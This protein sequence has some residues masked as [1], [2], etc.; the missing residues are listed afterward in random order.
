MGKYVTAT[1]QTETREGP[2]A[3]WRQSGA[4]RQKGY[5]MNPSDVLYGAADHLDVFGHCKNR[6]HGDGDPQAAPACAVGALR[7]SAGV[8]SSNVWLSSVPMAR[9]YGALAR[10]VGWDS[11]ADWN[12]DEGRTAEEVIATLRAAA[13][14][15]A[16]RESELTADVREQVTA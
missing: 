11:V 4:Q 13:V 3:V 9:A 15:E 6:L 8:A 5:K 10:Y 14:I 1:G 12:N 7:V 2:A 16:A